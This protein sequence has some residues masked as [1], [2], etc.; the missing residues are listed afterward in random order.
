MGIR[1]FSAVV[2]TGTLCTWYCNCL[3]T[4]AYPGVRYLPG[5]LECAL[6]K[7]AYPLQK[8]LPRYPSAAN[9]TDGRKHER[10]MKIA[11]PTHAKVLFV[12][13]HILVKAVPMVMDAPPATFDMVVK[14]AYV[15]PSAPSGHMDRYYSQPARDSKEPRHKKRRGGTQRDGW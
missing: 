6:G 1:V 8:L 14:M 3:K 5:S 12:T 13:S 10:H 15:V 4:S 7:H 11:R 2:T 9:E